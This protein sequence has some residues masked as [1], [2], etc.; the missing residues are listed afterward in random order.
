MVCDLSSV[1]S[2]WA[3]H[4]IALETGQVLYAFVLVVGIAPPGIHF[5]KTALVN[6][7]QDR[8]QHTQEQGYYSKSRNEQE[9]QKSRSRQQHLK[10]KQQN[11]QHIE[12]Y[13]G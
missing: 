12:S 5:Y 9:Q 1:P 8:Q 11:Q 6:S 2:W 7:L 4:A 3:A 13:C 10:E